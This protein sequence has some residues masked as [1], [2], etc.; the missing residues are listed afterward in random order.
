M[1]KT[2]LLGLFCAALLAVNPVY[3]LLVQPVDAAAEFHAKGISYVDSAQTLA[4]PER[5]FYKIRK[6]V[7]DQP[8]QAEN[9]LTANGKLASQFRSVVRLGYTLVEFQIDL[10][11]LAGEGETPDQPLSTEHLAQI[12]RAFDQMRENG[13]KAVLR[14][15]YDTDGKENP[16]PQ[17]FETIL[18]HLDQLK[19]VLQENSDVIYTVEAGMLGSYGEWHSGKYLTDKHKRQVIDKL[20]EV[21]PQDRAILLRRPQ[22]YRDQFGDSALTDRLAYS[23]TGRARIGFHNDA[24]LASE[25][26]M[27]T[28]RS[29]NREKELS[30]L[31]QHTQFVP[32]GGEAINASSSYNDLDNALKELGQTHCQYLNATYDVAV[33]DKWQ[34]TAYQGN[35]TAYRGSDGLKYIEDH[36]GYRY[37][38]RSSSVSSSVKQGTVFKVN[39]KIE[40]TGFG[41]LV[42]PRPVEL[43][44]EKDGTEYAAKLFADPRSWKAGKTSSLTLLMQAPGSIEPGNWNL[45]LRL[46]D[47]EQSLAGQNAYSI[48]FANEGLYSEQVGGNYIGSIQVKKTIFANHSKKFEQINR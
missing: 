44:L 48:R 46:P 38:L 36:L 43:V 22:F 16:E 47:A 23:G 29:W 37:V 17:Q 30:W 18:S 19:A 8:Y 2:R 11:A 39:L 9:D 7:L 28:Y 4:N 12:D 33:K 21:F 32:F 14:M 10:G 42:N 5:G 24:F 27:G 1:K 20:L 40:N 26:D 34:A 41:N 35:D 13:L 25:S 6:I 31:S 15:A 45:Y 3:G